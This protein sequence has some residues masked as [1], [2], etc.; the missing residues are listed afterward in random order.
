MTVP[1]CEPGAGLKRGVT[2]ATLSPASAV[3]ARADV[4]GARLGPGSL[5]ARVDPFFA[6]DEV[7]AV[8][9]RQVAGQAGRRGIAG[10]RIGAGRIERGGEGI[11]L[12]PIRDLDGQ[13]AI[14]RP[15]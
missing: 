14:E 9:R 4:A 8:A 11:E 10:V 12:S 3:S 13:I 7:A 5:S 15:A 1:R 6:F 2:A